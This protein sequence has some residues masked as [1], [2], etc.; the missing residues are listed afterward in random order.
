MVYFGAL[1]SLDHNSSSTTSK[2]SFHGTG[3]SFFQFPMACKEGILQDPVNVMVG[4]K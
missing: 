3:I 2:E 1:D 4:E